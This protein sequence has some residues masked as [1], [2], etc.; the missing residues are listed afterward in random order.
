MN[1][2]HCNKPIELDHTSVLLTVDGDFACSKQCAE[3]WE[4]E[5]DNFFTNVLTNDRA[6][7]QWLGVPKDMIT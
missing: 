5:R 6:F 3:A 2:S 1:C 4:K 7:V